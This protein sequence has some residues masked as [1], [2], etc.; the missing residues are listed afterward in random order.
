MQ[1]D[2]YD[3]MAEGVSGAAVVVCFMS[4]S[5]ESSNNCKLE[6]KFTA[7]SGIPIVPVMITEGYRA[8]GEIDF[9]RSRHQ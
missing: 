4:T 7:Q 8:S 6:L 2:I 5:Y 9:K 1:R 3:S